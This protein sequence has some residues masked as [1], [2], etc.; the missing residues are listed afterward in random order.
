MKGRCGT[1]YIICLILHSSSANIR[2]KI[3]GGGETFENEGGAEKIYTEKWIWGEAFQQPH[4]K[5]GVV[6]V[7]LLGLCDR[8]LELV[9]HDHGSENNV[10]QSKK[11]KEKKFPLKKKFFTQIWV[12]D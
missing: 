9:G 5:K 3:L 6:P 4:S 2:P 7:L 11:E 1:L 12:Q 10:F 8:E